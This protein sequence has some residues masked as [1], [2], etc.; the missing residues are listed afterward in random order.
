[1]SN[2]SKTTNFATKDSLSSGD[3]NKIVKGTEI[4]TEFN[5]IAIASATK[6]NT[7]E[8]TFTGTVTIPT[9]NVVGTITADTITGGTY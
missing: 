6:A 4:D 5:N 2:Y 8:P 7:A 1:M 9:L 3:A